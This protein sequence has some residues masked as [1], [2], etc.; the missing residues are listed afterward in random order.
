MLSKE[1]LLPL[2]RATFD[3]MELYKF[4][5]R[6]AIKN[7]WGE[8]GGIS[9]RDLPKILGR[10]NETRIHIYIE[11]DHNGGYF[12]F[13]VP[14]EYS[15]YLPLPTFA[16]MARDSQVGDASIEIFGESFDH[17]V[18]STPLSI[19]TIY[20]R[21]EEL[22]PKYSDYLVRDPS[23]HIGGKRRVR[24]K[25]PDPSKDHRAEVNRK[26]KKW[27]ARISNSTAD[28][29]EEFL[30]ATGQKKNAITDAALREYL[31]R[32]GPK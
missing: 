32:H 2:D 16:G 11:P 7:E 18:F 26:D 20:S 1:I 22:L 23:Q 4:D 9:P 12:L 13:F 30:K 21:N 24:E 19:I 29:A 31:E 10:E 6:K 25:F 17:I 14:E 15:K 28:R 27:Q 5:F 8:W 3:F